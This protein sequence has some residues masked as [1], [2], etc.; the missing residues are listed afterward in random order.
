MEKVYDTII[1]GGGPAGLTAA[2]YLA[3][4]N[5]N[6]LV[7][8]RGIPGGQMVNTPLI[9]NY[10]GF[11][12]V[13][14][15]TLSLEMKAQVEDLGVEIRQTDVL[16]YNLKG[17]IKTIKTYKETLSAKTVILA[18]GASSKQ[19]D[20][21]GEQ[22]FIGRGVSYCATC[23]GSLYKN[24]DVA[25]VGGG[26][27][28]FTDCIYLS[29]ICRKVYLIHRRDAFRADKVLED[30]VRNLVKSGK[31]EFVLNSTVTSI[32]GTNSVESI[33]VTNKITSEVIN[34]P[35]SALFVAIGRSPDTSLLSNQIQ[36]DASGYIITDQ[37]MQTSIAGVF[38]AGDCRNTLLRQI[39]TATSDGAIAAITALTYL[40][41]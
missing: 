25:V 34:I 35:V 38:A 23:D 3:R 9:E 32:Q 26:N 6:V 12:K 37:T 17:D 19:V 20:C 21:E 22:K 41:R 40:N 5:K 28:A 16:E 13:D 2:I 4:A 7:L 27:T 24:K 33:S 1:V 31:V 14:G 11:K 30:K 8:E 39:V 18:L 15:V 29:D 10:P 36:L